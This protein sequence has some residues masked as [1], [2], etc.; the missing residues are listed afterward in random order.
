MG[1]I[2]D[3]VMEGVLIAVVDFFDW[4]Y[5]IGQI[6]EYGWAGVPYP[7]NALGADGD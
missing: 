1:Y 6:K 5:V 2:C 4:K 3:L 7:C